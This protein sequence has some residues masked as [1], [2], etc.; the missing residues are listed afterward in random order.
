MQLLFISVPA[1]PASANALGTEK[2]VGVPAQASSAD[3]LE[4]R[5]MSLTL[6]K[7]RCFGEKKKK[8]PVSTGSKVAKGTLDPEKGSRDSDFPR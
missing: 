7:E 2:N 8:K 6:G 4:Y 1:P 3:V 5:R